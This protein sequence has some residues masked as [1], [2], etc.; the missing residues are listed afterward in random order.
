MKC[1]LFVLF[2]RPPRQIS[3]PRANAAREDAGNAL[4]TVIVSWRTDTTP[5]VRAHF[6]PW[7]SSAAEVH[8]KTA[9]PIY[10]SAAKRATRP[11]S[12][13]RTRSARLRALSTRSAV[14]IRRGPSRIRNAT[15]ATHEIGGGQYV[16]IG[17]GGG[18]EGEPSIV[19][20]KSARSTIND[21]S[22][23]IPTLAGVTRHAG[24]SDYAEC[25]Y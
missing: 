13:S 19:P 25:C 18:K 1:P 21:T 3:A 16:V 9:S 12:I 11:I 15:P 14:S 10:S 7:K 4:N 23:T 20:P 8:L 17:A 24:V 6:K 2:Q 5:Q 22:S